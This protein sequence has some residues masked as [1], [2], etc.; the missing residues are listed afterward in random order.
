MD[1]DLKLKVPHN[2]SP[3]VAGEKRKA[4]IENILK[5]RNNFIRD[6][7]EK[8]EEFD[9]NIKEFLEQQKQLKKAFKAKKN[10]E[11]KL[12]KLR[13]ETDLKKIEEREKE[14]KEKKLEEIKKRTEEFH[15]ETVKILDDWENKYK[16]AKPN[17]EYAY[18][19]LEKKYKR[20]KEKEKKKEETE[21]EMRRLKVAVPI[22][23]KQIEEHQQKYL[24][25]KKQKEEERLKQKSEISIKFHQGNQDVMKYH[26]TLD[27]MA[28]TELKAIR[29]RE[30]EI[31]EERKQKLEKTRKAAEVMQE[32]HKPKISSEKKKE[33]E[34]MISKLENKDRK[35]AKS[36]ISSNNEEDPE[37]KRYPWRKCMSRNPKKDKTQSILPD[38]PK[39]S[40][41]YRDYLTEERIR[42][43]KAKIDEKV[44]LGL[45]LDKKGIPNHE[46]IERVKE[47]VRE[48]EEKA[49]RKVQL[50]KAD[51]K[52]VNQ[53]LFKEASDIY[54]NSIKAKL[55]LLDNM[56]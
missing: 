26:R 21:M 53:D 17:Q 56:S 44:M 30:A 18:Q 46:K 25:E 4:Q 6:F 32:R 45:L 2:K 3:S 37:M 22:D 41:T 42:N 50:M 16:D 24:I 9:E 51:S 1:K 5:L 54:I 15:T 35:D 33:L 13:N 7:Q 12:K 38:I 36:D 31:R 52:G 29:Q 20:L 49:Q 14:K 40:T 10:K 48:M 47:K 11:N 34:E 55:S 27:D 39:R 8:R 23:P 19:K 43:P 28:E